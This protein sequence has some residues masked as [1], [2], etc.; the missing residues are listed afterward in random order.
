MYWRLADERDTFQS[1][2]NARAF[3]SVQRRGA[4]LDL[5]PHQ[6]RI[7]QMDLMMSRNTRPSCLIPALFAAALIATCGA[8]LLTPIN[9]TAKPASKNTED[10]VIQIACGSIADFPLDFT[11]NYDNE[12]RSVSYAE[13][14]TPCPAAD[15]PLTFAGSVLAGNPGSGNV[16][17][18][19]FLGA[20]VED[21][22]GT[23]TVTNARGFRISLRLYRYGGTL[24]LEYYF[25][26]T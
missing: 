24:Y 19:T 10:M 25:G 2:R 3:R 11:V 12:S 20:V 14:T 15:E 9:A 17:S 8:W 5:N 6:S 21:G 7:L 13:N 26:L 16:R 23:V 4:M 1:S 22:G 18:V